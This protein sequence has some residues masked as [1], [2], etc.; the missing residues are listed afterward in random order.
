ML[1]VFSNLSNPGIV[2]HGADLLTDRDLDP[3]TSQADAGKVQE[4]RAE[5]FPS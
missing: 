2:W 4:V 1:E 5:S 3:R